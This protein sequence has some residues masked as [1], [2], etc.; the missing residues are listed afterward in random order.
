MKTMKN[1]E[2]NIQ[3]TKGLINLVWKIQ[4]RKEY[5]L[6]VLPKIILIKLTFENNTLS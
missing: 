5:I 1:R 2:I 6:V 4:D 3:F